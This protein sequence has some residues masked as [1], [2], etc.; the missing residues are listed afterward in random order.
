MPSNTATYQAE[1]RRRNPDYPKRQKAL[2]KARRE[3][4]N[5]LAERYP[6]EYQQIYNQIKQRENL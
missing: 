4:L 5:T 2:E 3:A 1:Y 6:E